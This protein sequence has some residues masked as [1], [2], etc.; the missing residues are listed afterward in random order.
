MLKG[1]SPNISPVTTVVSGADRSGLS[2]SSA[3]FAAAAARAYASGGGVVAAPS[4]TYKV[5]ALP[6]YPGVT[7]DNRGRI[8]T[9]GGND[10]MF[11][12]VAG[13]LRGGGI[14]G[15]RYF[16]NGTSQPVAG[17]APAAYDATVDCVN[18]AAVTSCEQTTV[19]S[20]MY[21]E[22]FRNAYYGSQD[23]RDTRI[24]N[25]NFWYN[26]NGIWVVANHPYLSGV[27]D[28]R[29]NNYGLTGVTPYDMDVANQKFAY[30]NYGIVA[31]SGGIFRNCTFT[32]NTIAFSSETGIELGL[33]CNLLGGKLLSGS[34]GTYQRGVKIVESGVRVSGVEVNSFGVPWTV[35]AMCLSGAAT[36]IG[37]A[38]VGNQFSIGT[39]NSIGTAIIQELGVGQLTLCALD[40]NIMQPRNV[41]DRLIRLRGIAINTSMDNNKWYGELIAST[42]AV[43]EALEIASTSGIGNSYLTNKFFQHASATYAISA[44]VPRAWAKMN[45]AKGGAGYNFTAADAN[46]NGLGVGAVA[47]TDNIYVA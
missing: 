14:V 36:M 7:Y 32:G 15:G 37:A 46:T 9:S 17:S 21:V 28:I 25:C 13:V 3:A 4:G 19:F 18:L 31:Q 6:I 1:L 12:G 38:I 45:T 47:S 11:K 23:D 26:S 44:R 33:G 16:G 10:H 39:T 2:N 5:D 35:G 22:K 30:N 41:A 27:N 24:D 20:Q 40:G 8:F 43:I 42:A 29:L 34:S